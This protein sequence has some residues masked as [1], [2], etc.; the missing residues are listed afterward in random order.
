[1]LKEKEERQFGEYRTRRLVLEAWD[2]L[3]AELGPVVVRNYREELAAARLAEAGAGDAGETP[4]LPGASR[5]QFGAAA[6]ARPG[7]RA[8][9]GRRPAGS[10]RHPAAPSPARPLHPFH[11]LN[12]LPNPLTALSDAAPQGRAWSA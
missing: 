6:P 3:E 11:P 7:R 2:R 4:A 12:P 1:M 9:A 8:A 5:P 10:L